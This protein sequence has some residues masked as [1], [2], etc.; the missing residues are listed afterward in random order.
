MDQ[1]TLAKKGEN[2]IKPH[3]KSYLKR[4]TVIAIIW[5][6]IIMIGMISWASQRPILSMVIFMG[7]PITM[8]FTFGNLKNRL[9]NGLSLISIYLYLILS[10]RFGWWDEAGIILM[11]TPYVSLIIKPK[12]SLLKYGV[13]AFSTALLIYGFFTGNPV[14]SFIKWGVIILVY[15]IFLPP[16]IHSIIHKNLDKIKNKRPFQKKEP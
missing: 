8:I 1:E 3:L 9:V 2:C 5:M 16:I 15:V 10:L 7:L 14:N 13:T 12:R 6:I 4:Y 11:V